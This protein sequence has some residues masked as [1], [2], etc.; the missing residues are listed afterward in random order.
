[1]IKFANL[2]SA[3][4]KAGDEE[5]GNLTKRALSVRQKVA[6]D[7]GGILW[8][9][10]NVAIRCRLSR[11]KASIPAFVFWSGCFYRRG[12]YTSAGFVPLGLDSE[13]RALS[14]RRIETGKKKSLGGLPFLSRRRRFSWGLS[15]T[16]MLAPSPLWPFHGRFA[17]AVLTV[18]TSIDRQPTSRLGKLPAS[19]RM[20][21]ALTASSC[22]R[23][24]RLA[25]DLSRRRQSIQS[26]RKR[27]C[28]RRVILPESYSALW[29]G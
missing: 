25:K 13:F 23:R 24:D 16:S 11:R 10:N 27:S 7:F 28:A 26:M 15:S 18:W 8:V 12:A 22:C 1:L 14:W 21:L 9:A 19:N 29:T 2:R 4:E 17:S 6:I 3:V 5:L 20:H